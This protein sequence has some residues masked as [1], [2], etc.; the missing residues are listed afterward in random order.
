VWSV[1]CVGYG[2][3]IPGVS[4]LFELFRQ[5]MGPTRHQIQWVPGVL[6]LGV[7]R[8]GSGVDQSPPSA[9]VKTE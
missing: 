3:D 9:K 5:A 4:K 6:C 1:N 2:L 8:L 7:K